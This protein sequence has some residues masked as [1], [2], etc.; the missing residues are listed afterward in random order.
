MGIAVLSRNHLKYLE[1]AADIAGK[2]PARLVTFRAS[3][4]WKAAKDAINDCYPVPIYFV[5][6][7]SG[8]NV[9]YEATLCLSL[10]HI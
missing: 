10:I 5:P 2:D 4:R 9:K 7:G 8:I 1:S 3:T 6:V